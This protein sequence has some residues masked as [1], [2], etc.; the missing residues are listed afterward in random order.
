MMNLLIIN[1]N[2]DASNLLK[3]QIEKNNFTATHLENSDN[4][5]KIIFSM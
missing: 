1:K 4:A 3:Y 2:I 5:V